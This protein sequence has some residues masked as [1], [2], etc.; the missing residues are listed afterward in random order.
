MKRIMHEARLLLMWK[1]QRYPCKIEDNGSDC[2][3]PLV[4]YSKCSWLSIMEMEHQTTLLL[5]G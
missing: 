5:D 2:V 3:Q 4:K 1:E